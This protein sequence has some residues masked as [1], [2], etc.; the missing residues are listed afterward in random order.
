MNAIVMLDETMYARPIINGFRR[1]KAQIVW[2]FYAEQK[3]A[4]KW[5]RLSVAGQVISQSVRSYS[6]LDG[7][8]ADAKGSG[9]LFE[10]AQT[11]HKFDCSR[12]TRHTI[13][14][15]AA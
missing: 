13:Q 9:Y 2:R 11:G 12:H 10:P 6:S 4:W 8:V 14:S 3:R 7:C 1:P 15:P 5:Q